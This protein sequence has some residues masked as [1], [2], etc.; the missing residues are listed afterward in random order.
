M[1]LSRDCPYANGIDLDH[2]VKEAIKKREE[3]RSVI[4]AIPK[5]NSHTLSDRRLMKNTIMSLI[6][7]LGSARV[8]C[9]RGAGYIIQL[10]PIPIGER[11]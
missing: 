8:M 2:Y 10:C 11:S 6:E 1:S 9:P 5:E 7:S 3:R 4:S